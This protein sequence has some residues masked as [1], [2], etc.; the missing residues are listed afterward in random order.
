MISLNISIQENKGF[1]NKFCQIMPLRLGYFGF[2]KKKESKNVEKF[3]NNKDLI[4][5][6]SFSTRLWGKIKDTWMEKNIKNYLE[7]FKGK[8]LIH[9]PNNKE[10]VEKLEEGLNWLNEIL[11]EEERRRLIIEM[12]AFTKELFE[13]LKNKENKKEI[14]KD[15]FMKCLRKGFN[16]CLDTAHCYSN[17]LEVNDMFD[18]VKEIEEK[19]D[20]KDLNKSNLQECLII[21]LNGNQNDKY[22]MDHH[23]WILSKKNKYKKDVWKFLYLVK[24]EN[25]KCILELTDENEYDK[26]FEKY[27]KRLKDMGFDVVI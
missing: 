16:I 20:L 11:S 14:V 21:H 19:K 3:K 18:L 27:S 1:E 5:H 7:Y 9:G 23:T 12:P 15:Y 13:E 25:L 24:E 10:E 26:Y 22:N 4:I 2:G 6:A 17:G 8:L